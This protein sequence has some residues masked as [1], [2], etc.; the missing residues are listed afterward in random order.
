MINANEMLKIGIIKEGKIPADER[1]PL[2]PAQCR[3][4]MNQFPQIEICVQESAVRRFKNE[5]YKNEEVKVKPNIDDC[6]FLFGVKEVPIEMLIENKTYFFFSHTIKKQP[7]NKKL[8]QTVL[9][10]KIT[11]VDWETLKDKNGIRLIGFGK[12]AGIV[13]CYNAIYAWGMK[14]KIFQ[15]K[16]AYLCND[17]KELIT[18][19]N[20]IKM[21]PIKIAITGGGRVASGALEMLD[22]MKIKK[23]SPTDFL[24]KQFNEPVYTQLGVK[25]Y[26]R[27]S[28]RTTWNESD[29]FK[30]P[31]GYESNFMQYAAVAD[32]YL[33]CHFWDNKA[34]IIFSREDA[35][36]P[37][38]KIKVVAD[39]SCDVN[40]PIASTIRASTIQQ[41]LYGYNPLTGKEENYDAENA[42]TVMAVD[43]L[44]CEL[45]KDASQ[46]FGEEIIK[47]VLPHF[48]NNDAEEIIKNA[49]IIRIKK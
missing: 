37:Q 34:P 41:P 46:G 42:I 10:K 17:K 30:N 25:E 21:T 2:T 36:L 40:G 12:Y 38:F 24:E 23:V 3:S 48:L 32:M 28:D 5:E 7:Y 31:I 29:F 43:N 33:A 49:T 6:E 15:L 4:I 27:R 26:V 39:I 44:P 13:G 16:R 35:G 8:L 18:E 14:H 19:L 20:K 45:P 22:A 1:V 11:L 47:N 9:A